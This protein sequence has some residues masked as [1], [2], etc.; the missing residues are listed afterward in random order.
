MKYCTDN[1]AMIAALGHHLLKR[2][3]RDD[4]S[5]SATASTTLE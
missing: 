1:A 3:R 5:L 2:G 4:L